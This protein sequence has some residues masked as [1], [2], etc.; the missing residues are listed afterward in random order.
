MLKGGSGDVYINC[1][2]EWFITAYIIYLIGIVNG[3]CSLYDIME[4]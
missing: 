2:K 4:H 1:I 3:M